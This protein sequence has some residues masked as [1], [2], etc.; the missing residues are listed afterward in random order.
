MATPGRPL[1]YHDRQRLIKRREHGVSIRRLAKE[2]QLSRNTVRKY[3]RT[4]TP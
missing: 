4:S 3:V 1:D 2:E